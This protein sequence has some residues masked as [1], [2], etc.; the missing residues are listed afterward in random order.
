[1][2]Q[3][4][5][6]LMSVATLPLGY[7]SR[8]G[9]LIA[10]GCIL[11]ARMAAAFPVTDELN[12]GI[13]ANQPAPTESDLRHQLQLQ[14]GGF[15]AAANGGGWTF[16][17]GLG[18]YEFY[19][20]NVLGTATNRRWDLV[21]VVT[22][23]ISIFGDEPNVQVNFSYSPQF[24]LDATTPQENSVTQQLVGDGPVYHHPRRSVPRCAGVRRRRAFADGPR[25]TGG[26]AEPHV[27]PDEHGPDGP[28]A[29]ATLAEQQR[30]DLALCAAPLR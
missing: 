23:S 21:T 15:G 17:P 29:A 5:S 4:G 10:V 25:R 7:S 18:A 3:R 22:P 28:V 2:R 26:H 9:C 14:S 6:S 12:P 27:H 16:S 20:D 13:T 24:R 11:G 30:V 1:M 8:L 19:T